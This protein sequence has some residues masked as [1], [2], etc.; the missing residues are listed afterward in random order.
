MNE[1]GKIVWI[2]VVRYVIGVQCSTVHTHAHMH[3]HMHTH[4]EVGVKSIL[5]VSE[6]LGVFFEKHSK[7][8]EKLLQVPLGCPKGCVFSQTML[9]SLVLPRFCF[10]DHILL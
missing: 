4:E 7:R 1:R 9:F 6:V 5:E 3:T 10:E 8:P 2:V